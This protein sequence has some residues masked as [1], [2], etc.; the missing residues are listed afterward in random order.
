VRRWLDANR[1][2]LSESQVAALEE[3]IA[4][5]TPEV[6]SSPNDASVERQKAV[7]AR[8]A[9]VFPAHEMLQAVWIHG[10]RFPTFR[11]SVE[12]NVVAGRGDDLALTVVAISDAPA[13]ARVRVFA[14]G[15]VLVSDRIVT[16]VPQRERSVAPIPAP[17]I[18]NVASL[19]GESDDGP[20][21]IVV[22]SA[23][24]IYASVNTIPIR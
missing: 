12:L 16:L 24:P 3:N 8:T 22:Q 14:K 20:V 2:R 1:E 10:D 5:L 21:K 13:D 11:E 18:A 7:L 4:F 23:T 15:D 19:V 6:Y 17:A 9:A